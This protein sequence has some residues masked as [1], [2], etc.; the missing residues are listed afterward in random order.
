MIDL[1]L[2]KLSFPL[3]YLLLVPVPSVAMLVLFE[4]SCVLLKGMIKILITITATT[5][6]ASL[7]IVVI[8]AAA[9]V[10]ITSSMI[11]IV[12]P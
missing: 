6:T 9:R 2:F 10:V 12:W 7:M 5:T 8:M 1:C 3:F 11:V 4:H